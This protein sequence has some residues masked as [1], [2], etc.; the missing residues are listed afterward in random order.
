MERV[1]A[2]LTFFFLEE[3]DTVEALMA[4]IVPGSPE[5]PGAKEAGAMAYLDRALSGPYARW[6]NTYR[7][8]VRL[9]NAHAAR[10]HGGRKFFQLSEAEQDAVVGALEA[11]EVSGLDEESSGGADFFALLWAHAMEGMFSDPAYGGNRDAVGWKLVGFPGARYGYTAGEM[12][13]GADLS[14]ETPTLAGV[15]RL[16][17]ER[18][19]LFYHRPGPEPGVNAQEVFEAPTPERDPGEGVGQG[20]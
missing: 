3:A 16:A 14:D 11:G 15:E 9:I 19:D 6:R 12:R 8:A 10:G 5:D 2:G 20:Q 17:R 18:P 13:Y 7:D 4:R 1:D